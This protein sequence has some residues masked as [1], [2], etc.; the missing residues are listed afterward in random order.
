MLGE[1]LGS[2]SSGLL[3]CPIVVVEMLD[4]DHT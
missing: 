4:R 2:G 1:G 3:T